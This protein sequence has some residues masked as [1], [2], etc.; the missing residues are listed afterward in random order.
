MTI[1]LPFRILGVD[2]ATTKSGWAILDVLSLYPLKIQLIKH[3]QL[4]G[5]KL[6][7]KNKEMSK[8]FQ[9]QF[10][11]IDALE[12]TYIDLIE[13][14][15]PDVIVSESAF[16]YSHMSAFQALTLA[17][18]AL[19]RAAKRTLYKDIITIPPTISKK[20]ATGSGGADKET[21]RSAYDNSPYLIKYANEISE[22]EVDAIF[23]SVGYL[24]RDILGTV[25]QVS[26]LDRKRRKREKQKQKEKKE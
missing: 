9:K 3:G 6:L 20:A 22:H 19:R 23:H 18:D 8:I 14:Y 12:Q 21:M 26:A 1:K 25:V 5:Q 15:K 2:P 4:D 13:E 16:G 7:Q 11:V 17:I 24:M 10:C